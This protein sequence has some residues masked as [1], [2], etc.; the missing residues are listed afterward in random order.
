MPTYQIGTIVT[1]SGGFM[2]EPEGVKAFVYEHYGQDGGISLITEN[3]KDLGGFSLEEQDTYLKYYTDTGMT[4][5][6]KNVMQLYA[7]WRA[8]IFKPF[9]L[10]PQHTPRHP[11]LQ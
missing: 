4:Y 11:C 10:I 3:G 6:F 9:F 5:H 2:N 1:V 7:D 8:G